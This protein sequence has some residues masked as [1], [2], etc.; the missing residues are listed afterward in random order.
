MGTSALMRSGGVSAWEGVPQE[1][2]VGDGDF[3]HASAAAPRPPYVP[4]GSPIVGAEPPVAWWLLRLRPRPSWRV[5][6]NT[7]AK[8]G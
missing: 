8:P 7:A 6:L 3:E 2:A 5:P 1:G 4:D